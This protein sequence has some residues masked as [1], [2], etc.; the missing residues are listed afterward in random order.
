[1]IELTL[2]LFKKG[3][4]QM[5]LLKCPECFKAEPNAFC[6]C[7]AGKREISFNRYVQWNLGWVRWLSDIDPDEEA[8]VEEMESR[9]R[10]IISQCYTDKKKVMDITIQPYPHVLGSPSEVTQWYSAQ[11]KG[12]DCKEK[13]NY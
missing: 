6:G 4:R 3:L 10:E 2:E 1:M 12:P 13:N 9:C 7:C 8:S 11:F 5:K